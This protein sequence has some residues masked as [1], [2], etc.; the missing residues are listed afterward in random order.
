MPRV[1]GSTKYSMKKMFKL[2]LSG[3]TSFSDRP[4]IGVSV[5]GLL[6]TGLTG[7]Y[8]IWVLVSKIIW[9]DRS[10]PGYITAILLTLF[11]SGVQLLVLGLIGVYVSAVNRNV[12][13]RPEFVVW[14]DKCRNINISRSSAEVRTHHEFR[15][16]EPDSKRPELEEVKSRNHQEF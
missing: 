12:R 16:S 7:A 15:L 4:L 13:Q 10:V 3:V 8:S 2:G 9:P 14:S 1:A 5:C 11:L 6:I